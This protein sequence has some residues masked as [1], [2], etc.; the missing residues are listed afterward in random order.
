MIIQNPFYSFIHLFKNILLILLIIIIQS[1]NAKTSCRLCFNLTWIIFMISTSMWI[2][3]TENYY[4]DH[5][6]NFESF[7]TF[8][9]YEATF[10]NPLLIS[11]PQYWSR[12]VHHTGNHNKN[13]KFSP[14]ILNFSQKSIYHTIFQPRNIFDLFKLKQR[15]V[16]HCRLFSK[17]YFSTLFSSLWIIIIRSEDHLCNIWRKIQNLFSKDVDKYSISFIFQVKKYRCFNG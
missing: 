8:R 16:K 17:E 13:N 6:W 12:D 2:W 14:T 9:S 1:H 4:G 3:N 7:I 5:S 11:Y 10:L 15:N